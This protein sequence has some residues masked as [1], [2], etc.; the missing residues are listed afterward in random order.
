MAGF[1]AS[2]D[3]Y[4]SFLAVL[5]EGSLSGA[6]RRL[7]MS[8][9]TVGRHIEALEVALGDVVLFTRS[10][11]G[12]SPT[13]AALALQPHVHEMASAAEAVMR[14]ASGGADEAR[15]TVRVT[16]SEVIGA[17]VLP[18]ILAAFREQHPGVVIELVLT[19][20]TEDL[21]RRDADIA[22]R[23]IE[24]TQ[25]ALLSQKIG[26]V[27]IGLYGHRRYLE[28]HGMPQTLEDFLAR[29]IIGFD[30]RPSVTPDRI[31]SPTPISRSL[32]AFRSDSDLACLA[33]LRAGYGL[34]V[35]QA[36][37]AKRDLDLI[38]VPLDIFCFELGFWLT[39]HEDLKGV[40]RMRLLFDH[41][42]T[43]LRAY[44]AP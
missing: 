4:R 27:K 1:D 34:G 40:R 15:G 36:P 9:P 30:R 44:L 12:L 25:T 13:D 11:Q 39:M 38:P 17:E 33:A 37:L 32:F 18:Q 19:N 43:H 24:P 20:Q 22:V 5:S 23:M 3:L 2:W 21:L 29:P 10:Q 28:R 16:A 31:L 6:A 8:Q 14:A 35:C 26:V 7:R 42:A 41:L